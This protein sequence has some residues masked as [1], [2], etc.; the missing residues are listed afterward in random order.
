MQA[1]PSC[2]IALVESPYPVP[3]AGFEL[4]GRR[5]H[6]SASYLLS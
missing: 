3:P 2:G 4:K 1:F 6:L 5:L